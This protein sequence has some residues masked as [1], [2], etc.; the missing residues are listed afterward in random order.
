MNDRLGD[1]KAL[2][3]TEND[4]ERAAPL[5]ASK[6]G[7]SYRPKPVAQQPRPAPRVQPV[8]PPPA[9]PPSPVAAR[10]PFAPKPSRRQSGRKY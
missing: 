3:H 1:P 2:F 7:A 4:I 8:A 9:L 10:R 6:R 5:I